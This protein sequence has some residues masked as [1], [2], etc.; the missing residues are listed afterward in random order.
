[1]PAKR[2]TKKVAKKT[3]TKTTATK[4]S[5]AKTATKPRVRVRTYRHGLGDCHLL[6]FRKPGGGQCHVLIDFGVVNRTKEPEKVMTPVAKDIAK[7][8]GGVLDLVIATHQHTD[9]LSGFKQASAELEP[10]R[11]KMQRLWLAWTE[12]PGNDLGKKI[13]DELIG[14]LT[15][16][17]LAVQRLAGAG[18]AVADRIQ[19]TL[20]FFSPGVA[21]E[22]T[23]DILDA[24]QERPDV[25]I[26]YH[27]P[28]DLLALPGVPNVRVY[29]LGP[30]KDPAALK[31][32]NPRKS[33][34]EGYEL[35]AEAGG[36][37]DALGVGLDEEEHERS[38]PFAERH[39]RHQD[40]MQGN[41]FFDRFYFGITDE[42]REANAQRRIDTSWLEAAE[43]LALALGDY[44]NNTSLALAFEFVDTGEVLLFPGDAQ[45][46]SWNSWPSLEWRITEDGE[47]RTV[48]IGDLL[49]RTVFY[50][51]SHH[52][53]HNGTLS[54][55][56]A[57]AFGLEQMTHRDLV[58]VVP[59]D[60]EMSKAMNWDR[61][62]PWQPLLTRLGE[63]TRGRLVLT[64][65]A[66]APPN[67]SKLDALSPEERKRFAKAVVVQNGWV[68]YTR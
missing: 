57:G 51:A 22:D 19:G 15:A 20:D 35:A 23:Q 4:K 60:I 30:P 16:V 27:S 52:A 12:D 2:V 7:E 62:L 11:V 33:K 18:S 49:A 43:Q 44:T 28:G 58:C 25:E 9:H 8:T 3:T 21:G 13:R 37:V 29:V 46:G 54:G 64:D 45:I 53:S 10:A 68:D 61:T 65:S 36:F 40:S 47:T 26:E 59:V 66:I 63:V 38:Q 41:E 67:A 42:E 1:M 31:V 14:K 50:K 32:T 24:L 56:A 5:A 17:R 34:Q 48:K 39:R 55:R 6:S